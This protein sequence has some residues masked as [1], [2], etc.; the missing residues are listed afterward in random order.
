MATEGGRAGGREGGRV[1]G[2]VEGGLG[3]P[4]PAYDLLPGREQEFQ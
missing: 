3:R 4:T 2:W 1:G